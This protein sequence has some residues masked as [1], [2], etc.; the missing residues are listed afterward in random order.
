MHEASFSYNQSVLQAI[1]EFNEVV[2]V[3][4][5]NKAKG[6]R[7]AV[8]QFWFSRRTHYILNNF[9]IKYRLFREFLLHSLD[10]RWFT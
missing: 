9:K 1:G 7:A 4:Q 3:D 6:S 8:S 10:A 5:E 2:E